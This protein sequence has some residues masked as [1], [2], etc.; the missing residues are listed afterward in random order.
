MRRDRSLDCPKRRAKS[1]AKRVDPG[2][3]SEGVARYMDY[4]ALA[5]WARSALE[6]SSELPTD[7]ARE[8]ERRRPGYLRSRSTVNQQ[9]FSGSAHDWERLMLWTG[10]HFFQDAKIEGWFDAILTQVRNHPR[11]IRTMEFADHCDEVW[12]SKLP[13]PYPPFADWRREADLYVELPG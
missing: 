8:I 13:E 1:S 9:T 10:D 4:E 12:S 2:R 6:S 5:Y 3:L 11:A 7:V